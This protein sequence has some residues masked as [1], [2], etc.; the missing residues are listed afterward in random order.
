MGGGAIWPRRYWKENF[1][2]RESLLIV[3]S[4]PFLKNLSNIYHNIG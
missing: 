2:L 1:A 4:V 3:Q